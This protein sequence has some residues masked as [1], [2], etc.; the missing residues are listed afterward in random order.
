MDDA[1]TQVVMRRRQSTRLRWVVPVAIAVLGIASGCGDDEPS[2]EEQVCDA[3]SE[4]RGAL[5]DVVSDL[6][7]ANLGDANEALAEAGDALDELVAAVED[8]AQEEREAL[9]PEVDA[10]ESDI[11]ALQDAEDLDEL[12]AGLDSVL[13]QAQVIFDDVTE[14][15][16][17]D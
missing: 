16:S 9:A 2:A 12:G 6:Q 17:C 4:L 13:S 10:L 1:E 3:Q 5:D 14:T 7:A 15:A 8:L 11:A